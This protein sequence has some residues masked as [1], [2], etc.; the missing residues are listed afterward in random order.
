LK[1]LIFESLPGIYV[2][3]LVYVPGDHSKKHPAVLVPAG[4]ATNGKIHYQVLSQRLASRGYVVIAWDPVGQGERSQFWD[5]KDGKSRYNLVCAEHAVMG[6]LAY[7]V[8][9]IWRAGRFGME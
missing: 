5:A 3:A 2:T 6:N 9:A 4:H 1:K 8:G 7:L